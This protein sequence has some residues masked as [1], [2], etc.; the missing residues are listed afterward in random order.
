MS[1]NLNRPSGIGMVW[2]LG[3]STAC[4]VAYFII[5]AHYKVIAAN[6]FLIIGSSLLMV[7]ALFML[8]N[9]AASKDDTSKAN[10][11]LVMGILLLNII[12]LVVMFILGQSIRFG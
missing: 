4:H 12:T 10:D 8:I 7:G 11:S 9:K 5:I 3:A 6:I 2:S 1:Y